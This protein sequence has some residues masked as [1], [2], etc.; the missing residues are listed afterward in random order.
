[1][2][3]DEVIRY[4]ALAL[5]SSISGATGSDLFIDQLDISN[6]PSMR[7]ICATIHI[8]LFEKV[9]SITNLLNISKRQF[10]EHA[11]IEA[12]EKANSIIKEVNPMEEDP[13]NDAI[14][15]TLVE[16]QK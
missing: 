3:F 6:T 13:E 7:N 11:L 2:N 1:M 10:V 4:K 8:S 9:E 5:K 15:F 16:E 14:T 12:V